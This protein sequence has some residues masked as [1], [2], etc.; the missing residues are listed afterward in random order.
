[1]LTYTSRHRE[2]QN[3][4]N[5]AF[6]GELLNLFVVEVNLCVSTANRN[7]CFRSIV[8]SIG[9]H[10]KIEKCTPFLLIALIWNRWNSMRHHIFLQRGTPPCT[11]VRK[12]RSTLPVLI[13]KS[14]QFRN[15][16]SCSPVKVYR[17]M[18]TSCGSLPGLFFDPGDGG[19]MFLGDA[20]WFSPNYM[21]LYPRK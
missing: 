5:I 12:I 14:S 7:F 18:P 9:G 4:G 2:S 16:K 3:T 6:H 13:W 8:T 19:G 10:N 20:G 11:A 17:P 1:M 21:A 15:I